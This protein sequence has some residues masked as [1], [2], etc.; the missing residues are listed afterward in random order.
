MNTVGPNTLLPLYIHPIKLSVP[1][2]AKIHPHVFMIKSIS[3]YSL[4][5]QNHY[6]SYD[7]IY[8]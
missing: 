4:G 1:I 3:V 7:H 8:Q 6:Q 5:T 2:T